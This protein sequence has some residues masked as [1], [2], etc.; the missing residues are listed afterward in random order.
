M[1]GLARSAPLARSGE[2]RRTGPIRS[3]PAAR[4]PQEV[5]ARRTVGERS[6][7]QCEIAGCPVPPTDWSH[8]VPRSAGGR[9][10]VV[11]GLALCRPHHAWCHHRPEW[12]QAAG[13]TLPG[14][15]D[16]AT[17]PVWL[18][19]ESSWLPS[20]SWWVLDPEGLYVAWDGDRPG[21]AHYPTPAGAR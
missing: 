9:W 12:S 4:T 17:E 20:A 3:A 18:H 10:E 21:P 11:N 1:T 13:L 15:A 6:N 8:R 5:H 19:P 7:G 14:W 2:L 16:P